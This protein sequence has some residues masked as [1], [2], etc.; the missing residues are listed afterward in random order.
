MSELEEKLSAL[1][2]NP[3]LMEQISA[4]AQAMGSPQPEQEPETKGTS[5]QSIPMPDPRLLQVFSQTM[6]RTGV[7]GNQEALLQALA[8]Y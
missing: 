5:Q 8:P 3:Q 7:D 2:S 4:M 1:M 6:G